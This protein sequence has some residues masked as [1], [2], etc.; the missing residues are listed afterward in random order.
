[1]DKKY[2]QLIT[3]LIQGYHLEKEELEDLDK[4]LD[5]HKRTIKL[6]LENL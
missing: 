2:I 1:M 4:Y 6:R 3:Q 5:S